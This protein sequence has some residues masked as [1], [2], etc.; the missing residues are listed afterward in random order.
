MMKTLMI[1]KLMLKSQKKPMTLPREIAP[2]APKR[3][4]R[5]NCPPSHLKDFHCNLITKRNTPSSTPFP[6][7]KYL[8]YGAYTYN[9]KNYLLNVVSVY[10]PTYYHQVPKKVE[11]LA[12]KLNKS[13]YGPKQALRQWFVKFYINTIFIWLPQIKI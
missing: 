10:E 11:K 3:P 4:S 2:I 5:Q 13:I 12:C 9:H 7:T 6:L 8:L 1:K